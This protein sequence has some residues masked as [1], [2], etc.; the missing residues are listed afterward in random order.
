MSDTCGSPRGVII[1]IHYAVHSYLSFLYV[2]QPIWC[3]PGK[4]S[5][6]LPS[7]SEVDAGAG[8]KE[9]Q[10]YKLQFTFNFITCTNSQLCAY[11][12][13]LQCLWS[14]QP[15]YSIK[16]ITLG[17]GNM[18]TDITIY[19]PILITVGTNHTKSALTIAMWYFFGSL[20]TSKAQRKQKAHQK[21]YLEFRWGFNYQIQLTAL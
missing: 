11:A 19:S 14:Y 6:T 1:G 20:L 8:W 5:I 9:W 13:M 18:T 7:Q 16:Q 4:H 17:L 15:V 3:K 10:Q 21:V 2:W 12:A